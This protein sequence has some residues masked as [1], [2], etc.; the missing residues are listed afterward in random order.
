MGDRTVDDNELPEGF[1]SLQYVASHE[2][3]IEAI[4]LD[5]AAAAQHYLNFGQAEGRPIDDFDEVQ[6]L[7]NYPDLREA[8]GDDTEDDAVTDA[9]TIHYIQYGFEEGRTDASRELPEGFDS[10]QYIA[11][12][13]DL[14][15]ALGAD[16]AAGA[17]H[18]RD[19]GQVE[20][21]PTD[22]FDEVQYLENYPDLREAFGDDTEND[23]VTDAATIHYIEFGY[24]EERTD[25][26]LPGAAAA[27]DFIV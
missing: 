21:R 24:A 14:I 19:F 16:A 1:D 5:A 9:A 11:S 20:G 27:S 8:F 26:D 15:E 12:N 4:G 13:P 2:N 23:A 10:F 18:Y 7:E 6:Y 25:G 17:Q 22:D 3:L